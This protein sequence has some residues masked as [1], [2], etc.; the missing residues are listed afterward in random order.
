MI[1][2]TFLILTISSLI[3]AGLFGGRDGRWAAGMIFLAVLLTWVDDQLFPSYASVHQAA[4]LIDLLLLGALI[5]LMLISRS[6]WPIWMAAA[7]M[8]TAI[9]HCAVVFVPQFVPRIYYAVS[10]VWAVPCLAAMVIGIALDR[11][12]KNFDS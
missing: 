6:F 11:R 8:L 9:S 5:A 2:I 4:V 10:T 1:Q 3:Y 12:S 7:Q